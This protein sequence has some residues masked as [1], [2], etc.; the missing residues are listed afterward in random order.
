MAKKKALDKRPAYDA[1]RRT[2]VVTGAYSFIGSEVLRALDADPRYERLI[3]VD[4]RKP[5]YVS[6][7]LQFHKIDLTLPSAEYAAIKRAPSDELHLCP[8][9]GRILIR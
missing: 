4:I 1:K 5:A 3:A 8:E 9:C 2:V 7:K 6:P